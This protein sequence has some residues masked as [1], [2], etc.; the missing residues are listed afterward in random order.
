MGWLPVAATIENEIV[1]ACEDME[2]LQWLTEPY[3][4]VIPKIF[5]LTDEE[6]AW[7]RGKTFDFRIIYNGHRAVKLE[8]ITRK[9]DTVKLSKLLLYKHKL[10]QVFKGRIEHGW[11]KAKS[12]M[13]ELDLVYERKYKEA[14]DIL[15]NKEKSI[16]CY[17]G[18]VSD[19]ALETGMKME[20]AARLIKVKHENAMT[21]IRKLERLRIRHMSAIKRAKTLEELEKIHASIDKDLFTNM[22]L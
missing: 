16:Y 6:I 18:L 11:H 13:P 10:Y 19:Y 3:F 17:D 1:Y 14:L 22:L 2:E 12:L 4:N 20:H 7:L 15:E 8:S 9:E 5:A 21:H